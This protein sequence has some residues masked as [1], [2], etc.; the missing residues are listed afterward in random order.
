[1]RGTS[2]HRAGHG[3]VPVILPGHKI[4]GGVSPGIT[5]D[6]PLNERDG[7]RAQYQTY[8]Q[9][10]DNGAGDD[11]FAFVSHFCISITSSNIDGLI[12]LV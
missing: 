6:S 5:P 4:V 1:M 9:N 11:P 2:H 12:I 3:I 7:D 8:Y 10:H